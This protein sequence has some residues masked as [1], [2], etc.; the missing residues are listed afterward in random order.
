MSVVNKMAVAIALASTLSACVSYE[1]KQVRLDQ[2]EIQTIP[3]SI[4]LR[5][6]REQINRATA[7]HKCRFSTK[8][9]AGVTG[10]ANRTGPG[11][12]APYAQWRVAVI[13]EISVFGKRYLDIRITQSEEGVQFMDS[14]P[15]CDAHFVELRNG[16]PIS[17][18]H[19][20]ELQKTLSALTS[21]GVRY[22]PKRLGGGMY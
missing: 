10:L 5:Y 14:K 1:T 7:G 9:I 21:L 4:A 16:E 18:S 3:S 22:D 13:G 17:A 11:S 15:F 6:L 19:Q 2:A 8:G 20:K 12:H